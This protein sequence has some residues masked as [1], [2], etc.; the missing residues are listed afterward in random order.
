LRWYEEGESRPHGL[1]LL[2]KVWKER[3]E[4]IRD[5]RRTGE[6]FLSLPGSILVLRGEKKLEFC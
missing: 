4:C 6:K 3:A 5:C 1:A 2:H